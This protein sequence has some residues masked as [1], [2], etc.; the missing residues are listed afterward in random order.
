VFPSQREGEHV[1]RDQIGERVPTDLRHARREC[2]CS[3][4][5]KQVS[6]ARNPTALTRSTP[7]LGPG[8]SPRCS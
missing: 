5:G 4:N 2:L 8:S 3:P 6:G 1:R 7:P